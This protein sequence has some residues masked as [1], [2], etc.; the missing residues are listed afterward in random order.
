MR[1]EL[2]KF[3]LAIVAT[4]IVPRMATATVSID[5]RLHGRWRSD[6]DRTLQALPSAWTADRVRAMDSLLGKFEWQFSA[7]MLAVIEGDP[8]QGAQTARYPMK[9]VASDERSVVLEVEAL[10]RRQ[11]QQLFFEKDYLYSFSGSY[12]EYLKRIEA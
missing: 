10:G 12:V 2:L 6:R 7:D 11:L 9:I 1:R 3:P 5:P 8:R 4:A